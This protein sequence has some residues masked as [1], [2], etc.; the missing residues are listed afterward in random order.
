MV[1]SKWGYLTLAATLTPRGYRT[2]A[3][4][5]TLTENGPIT[6][7][8]LVS[9]RILIYA[10]SRRVLSPLLKTGKVGE[11]IQMTT[12]AMIKGESTVFS[13]CSLRLSI[14]LM[15]LYP[16]PYDDNY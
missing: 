6:V 12:D 11:Q 15:Y 13:V 10:H 16:N 14:M 8:S 4:T 3:P 2:L 9:L 7:A 1:G 5:I